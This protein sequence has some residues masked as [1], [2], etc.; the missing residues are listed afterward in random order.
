MPLVGVENLSEVSVEEGL[1][2]AGFEI[3]FE[4]EIIFDFCLTASAY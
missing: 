1:A 4:G 3:A 2:G